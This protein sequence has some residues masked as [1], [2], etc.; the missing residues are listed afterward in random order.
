MQS[1][2]NCEPYAV[3]DSDC[4]DGVAR[5]TEVRTSDI[6]NPCAR[7]ASASQVSTKVRFPKSLA[8]TQGV[9]LIA[10]KTNAAL[11]TLPG[12]MKRIRA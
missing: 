4:A 8:S 9:G 2:T 5:T 11:K 10:R 1:A 7:L 3:L 6:V 12:K